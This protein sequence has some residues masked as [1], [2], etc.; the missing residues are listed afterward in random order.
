MK[1]VLTVVG[2]DK[3][4][5]IAE[6]SNV[7]KECNVNILDISQT[8]MQGMFTMIMLVDLSKANGSI[9]D[10]SKELDKLAENMGLS[11]HIQSEE[12]F[13]SMHRI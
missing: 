3:V 9:K 7:L 13:N 2:N 4:G 10:I 5:I 11:I 12:V 1:A 6:V 8:I